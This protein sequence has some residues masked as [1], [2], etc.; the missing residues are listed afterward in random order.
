M[1][2]GWYRNHECKPHALATPYVVLVLMI[3]K[4]SYYYCHI[5][6]GE[7]NLQFK[8][9]LAFY[10]TGAGRFLL[11]PQSAHPAP[12]GWHRKPPA[13][14]IYLM[15]YF[16]RLEQARPCLSHSSHYMS[17]KRYTVQRVVVK[18][19]KYLSLPFLVNHI[20]DL[21]LPLLDPSSAYRV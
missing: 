17:I 2:Y 4:T 13:L 9:F 11:Q 18:L 15:P 16:M 12:C 14:A 6:W 7:S 1:V 19:S 21:I 5:L 3:L 8:S 20:Q 10:V